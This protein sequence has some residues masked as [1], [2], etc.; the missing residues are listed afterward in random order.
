MERLY[1]IELGA[2][3]RDLADFG[4]PRFLA[5]TGGAEGVVILFGDIGFYHAFREDADEL[6]RPDDCFYGGSRRFGDDPSRLWTRGQLCAL[7]S[8]LKAENLAVYFTVFDLCDPAGDAFARAHGEIL[9]RLRDGS[10]NPS[11][12]LTADLADGRRYCDFLAEKAARAAKFCGADGLH[13]ADGISTRRI[14]VQ[15]LR[16]GEEELRQVARIAEGE[17]KRAAEKLLAEEGDDARRGRRVFAGCRKAWLKYCADRWTERFNALVGATA[18]GGLKIIMNVAWLRDPFESYYRY[19]FDY[20]GVDFSAV[21]A[22]ITNDVNRK[23]VPESDSLGFRMSGYE[24]RYCEND[25]PPVMMCIKG[26]R[27]DLKQYM[28]VPVRDNNENWDVMGKMPHACVAKAFRRNNVWYFDGTYRRVSEGELYCLSSGVSKE[29]WDFVHG[30]GEKS[31]FPA[32]APEGL[33]LLFSDSAY[34][35]ETDDYLRA[36][37]PSAFFAVKE[38]QISGLPLYAVTRYE[39][40]NRADMPL[41]VLNGQNHSREERA[42][43]EGYTRTPLVAFGRDNPLRRTPDRVISCENAV[44]CYL[45]NVPRGEEIVLPAARKNSRPF[46]AEECAD[47]IWIKRLDYRF[48]DRGRVRRMG[49]EICRILGLCAVRGRGEVAVNF[50]RTPDG[51]TAVFDNPSDRAVRVGVNLGR[52]E[53]AAA[54]GEAQRKGEEVRVS[55]PPCG[56]EA[57]TVRF[58]PRD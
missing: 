29:E 40:L 27:P 15:I 19:G 16:C 10:R 1:W 7:V 55:V 56:A 51:R 5:R 48:P 26:L 36:R 52:G 14:P 23:V 33:C 12:D 53:V 20:E 4:V 41:V 6:L 34:R 42:R 50:A 3:D 21:R 13:L 18:A 9:Q 31:R 17:E 28:L 35:A 44:N 38:L 32:L 22:V 2:F 58:G 11:V 45:F 43:L 57:V 39:F 30:A 46:R 8:R 25:A 49:R 37:T 47:G 54:Y 24:T